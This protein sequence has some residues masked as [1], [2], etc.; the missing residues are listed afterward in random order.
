MDVFSIPLQT[1]TCPKEV[2][3][4]STLLQDGQQPHGKGLTSLAEPHANGFHGSGADNGGASSSN[5]SEEHP[6]LDRQKPGIEKEDSG[7]AVLEEVA[8]GAMHLGSVL[9]ADLD[10]APR[11]ELAGG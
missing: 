7:D 11:G 9:S 6:F 1:N 2:F 3:D 8:V 5:S 10:E 4:A